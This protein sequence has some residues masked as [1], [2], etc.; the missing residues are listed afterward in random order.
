MRV[1]SRDTGEFNQNSSAAKCEGKYG[2]GH[3][4]GRAAAIGLG[5]ISVKTRRNKC[6]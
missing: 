3:C 5:D 6:Y 2:G 4:E 1:V